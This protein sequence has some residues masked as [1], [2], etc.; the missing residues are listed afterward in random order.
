MRKLGGVG[1]V[2]LVLG[3]VVVAGLTVGLFT[4]CGGDGGAG[5]GGSTTGGGGSGGSGSLRQPA[6]IVDGG[7]AAKGRASGGGTI[8]VVSQGA[9]TLGGAVPAA[10]P[11]PAPPADA[12]A[13]ASDALGADVTV[14]GSVRIDGT[15]TAGGADAICQITSSGGD[16]FVSGDL[17]GGD[18]GGAA[19]GLTLRAPNGTIYV[20]GTVDSGGAGAGQN[21]GAMILAAQRVVVTGSLSAAGADGPTGGN[22]ATITITAG[23]VVYLGGPV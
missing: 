9:T 10:P 16:I 20:S 8:H 19:R 5:G 14:A 13:I 4:G 17:H 23:D 1:G 18:A 11:I 7:D 22:A 3:G 12:T 2:G 6:W 21:G 15:Q